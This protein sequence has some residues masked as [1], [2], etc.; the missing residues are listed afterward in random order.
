MKDLQREKPESL[1]APLWHTALLLTAI[2]TSP[3]LGILLEKIPVLSEGH[4]HIRL[5]TIVI[6]SDWTFFFLAYAGT[7]KRTTIRNLFGFGWRGPIV[8]ARGIL[9]TICFWTIWEATS[10]ALHGFLGRVDASVVSAM[11]P[12]TLSEF[13]GWTL[14]SVSPG[15]CEEF[16]YRGYLQRQFAA[17]TRNLSVAVIFQAVVFG[18]SHRYQGWKQV[19]IIMVFGV[20]LGLLAQWRRSLVP[21]ICAH[22]S[23]DIYNGWLRP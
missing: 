22:A 12:K 14:A 11:L 17:I 8:F 13:I 9:I 7:W 16:I 18:L 6:L 21:G 3:F 1:I 23:A 19:V 5:Y 2:A 15:I 10:R 4:T 20:L